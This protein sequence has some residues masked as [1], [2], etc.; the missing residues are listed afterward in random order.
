MIG[1][2]HKGIDIF[3]INGNN[4]PEGPPSDFI[5]WDERPPCGMCKKPYT[6]SQCEMHPKCDECCYNM[7]LRTQHLVPIED[8]SKVIITKKEA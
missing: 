6:K 1:E 3:I 8:D 4:R 5:S 2:R 7:H